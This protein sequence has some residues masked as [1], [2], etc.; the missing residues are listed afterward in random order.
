MA[1]YSLLPWVFS[2]TW[3]SVRLDISKWTQMSRTVSSACSSWEKQIQFHSSSK[4]NSKNENDHNSATRE[5]GH[6]HIIFLVSTLPG[7]LFP[8]VNGIRAWS[9]PL[10]FSNRQKTAPNSLPSFYP[11]LMSQ[12]WQFC[13]TRP[14]L[15]LQLKMGLLYQPIMKGMCV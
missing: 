6:S 9:S 2:D 14:L 4:S 5:M 7:C 12:N 1:E 15:V 3:S 13:G 10:T 11:V 8:E